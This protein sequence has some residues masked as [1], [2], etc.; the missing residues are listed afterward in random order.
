MIAP[1]RRE[2]YRILC[3]ILVAGAHSDEA[4]HSERLDR[5]ERRDRNLITDIVYGTLRWLGRLDFVLQQQSSRSWD[6]IDEKLRILLRMSLYQI[7]SADRIPDYAV[8]NDA[9]E[10]TKRSLGR[11]P[12]S[13]ANAMLRRLG[14]ERPWEDHGFAGKCPPWVRVSLPEWLWSRW[15]TRYGPEI[16]ADFALS[17]NDVPRVC[18]RFTP[19]DTPPISSM[20]GLKASEVVR[21]AY[22]C[23][24]GEH[25]GARSGSPIFRI[26]DEASQLIPFLLEPI[27][28]LAI[29]DACAAPG[30]KTAILLELCGPK[31]TLVSCDLNWARI[32]RLKGNMSHWSKK[33]TLVLADAASSPP[34]IDNCFDVILT[35]VPCSGLGTLRR[36]PEIKWRLVPQRL[37]Q[38]SRIQLDILASSASILRKGGR[39]LYSTCSTEP[40]ENEQVI[41]R[42]LNS[43]PNFRLER[44]S[45]PKGIHQWL[46]DSG[47]LRTFP[48]PRFWDGFFGALM[49]REI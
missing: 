18:V 23:A 8:V 1:A 11:G 41:G 30:G 20:R 14:R 7:W 28:G 19:D 42:F 5:L 13:F 47:M 43:H 6:R 37:L 48:G 35:D 32:K 46:D 39:I 40:E 3:E 34:F 26:Q 9:V 15:A 36:N 29:W 33:A 24:P 45:N 12:A 21:G 38:F 4:L 31:V 22:V 17:L 27:E 49:V 2:S 44:P 10:L 25:F 16:A